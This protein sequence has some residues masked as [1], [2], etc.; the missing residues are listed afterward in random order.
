MALDNSTGEIKQIRGSGPPM[1]TVE[2]KELDVP[3][4]V[5]VLMMGHNKPGVPQEAEVIGLDLTKRTI[6]VQIVSHG[7]E[8]VISAE[9]SSG[10]TY[11]VFATAECAKFNATR[12]CEAAI[13]AQEKRIDESLKSLESLKAELSHVKAWQSVS[14]GE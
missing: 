3:S 14:K 7:K 1:L 13:A 9:V 8:L 2:K 12:A 4:T 10:A 6:R 11:W 5:Y